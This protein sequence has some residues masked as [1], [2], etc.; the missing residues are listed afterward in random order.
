MPQ[1]LLQRS[2]FQRESSSNLTV[3]HAATHTWRPEKEQERKREREKGEDLIQPLC[4]GTYP[5]APSDRG[6]A[7]Q[8]RR[9]CTLTKRTLV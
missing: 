7:R 9:D 5:S 3:A 6:F 2:A 1:I 4:A 8:V